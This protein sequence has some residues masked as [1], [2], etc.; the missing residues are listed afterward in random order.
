M[1]FVLCALKKGNLRIIGV[2]QNWSKACLLVICMNTMDC[3][4]ILF[5][6]VES[7]IEVKRGLILRENKQTN[8][9]TDW[10]LVKIGHVVVL[11]RRVCCN[12][13]SLIHGNNGMV[14]TVILVIV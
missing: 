11:G 8:V 7:G 6:E 5:W 13:R 3:C 1:V 9:F 14:E 4:F 2:V 12:Q 10:D